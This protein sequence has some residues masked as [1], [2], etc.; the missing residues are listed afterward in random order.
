MLGVLFG[1]EV[2]GVGVLGVDEGRLREVA[3]AMLRRRQRLHVVHRLLPLHNQALLL[4]GLLHAVGTG[5]LR[6][7]CTLAGGRATV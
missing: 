6:P 2:G 1:V 4:V 5:M 3:H 7:L